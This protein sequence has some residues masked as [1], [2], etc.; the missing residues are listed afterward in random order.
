MSDLFVI[1]VL[2]TVIY[3]SKLLGFKDC[4]CLN[5][6]HYDPNTDFMD[7]LKNMKLG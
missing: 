5:I 2:K 1:L 4:E 3:I 6:E 7:K